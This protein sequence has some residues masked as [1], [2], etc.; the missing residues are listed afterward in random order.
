M[1]KEQ[2][3]VE[4][5]TISSRASIAQPVSHTVDLRAV[6][7]HPISINSVADEFSTEEKL[8]ILKRLKFNGLVSWDDLPLTVSFMLEK[9]SNITIEESIE[10]LRKYL[11]VHDND[12]NIPTKDYE[13][14][15]R[16]V[17][18]S[19]EDI[20]AY[21]NIKSILKESLAVDVQEVD[22]ES[23]SHDEYLIF[24]WRLQIRIEAAVIAYWSPY[25]EVRSVTDPYDDPNQAAETLRVY[26]I[27]IIWTAIGA[28]INQFF[29]QRQPSI[30]V[31]VAV[32]Q[33]F[34]YPS[35]IFLSKILPCYTF[36]LKG[37]K[38][39]LNPGPWT[40]KE[41]MI[42]TIMYGTAAASNFVT[43]NIINQKLSMFYNSTNV[44]WGYQSLLSLTNAFMG[45]GL[46]GIMR[47]F[48]IYPEVAMWPSMLP[49]MALN[50]ALVNPEKKERINGWTI[51]RYRFFWVVAI[52][53]FLWFWF[54]TY[55][56]QALSFF[57]W[58]TWIKPD[59]F[60]LAMVTGSFSGLGLNP[61]PSFDWSVL[62]DSSFAQPFYTTAAA[63]LGSVIALFFIAG[64]YW[65]NNSWTAYLPIN[66]NRMF[67]NKGEPY[68]N[69]K[70]LNSKNL[71]DEKGY[72][73]YG[74]PFYS[75]AML[76]VSGSL[77][78]FYPFAIVFECGV[79]YKDVW[80][81]LKNSI[82]GI[83]NYKKSSLQEFD[84][85]FSTM[86]Q[87][88][89][90]VPEYVFV[91]VLLCSLVFGIVCVKVYPTETPVWGI[92]FAIGINFVF[93]IPVTMLLART[94]AYFSLGTLV[95]LIVGYT[96]PGNGLAL[97]FIKA[98][99][100]N[101]DEQAENYVSNLKWAHYSKIAPWTM[102]RTQMVSVVVGNFVGLAVLNF[103]IDSVKGFCTVHQPEK[104]TC[105]GAAS[106]F[107]SSILW[108]V[109]GPKKVFGGLYPVMKYCFLIGFLL[110]LV[111]LAFKFYA[112][113]KYTKYFEPSIFLTGFQVFAPNNLSY[114]TGGLYLSAASMWYL[115]TRYQAFWEKYNYIFSSGLVSGIACCSI[116]IFFSVQYHPKE[117]NWWGNEVFTEGLDYNGA[118]LLNAT[119]LA[120]DG[121]FGPR[122]GH[123]P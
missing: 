34:M 17:E 109:I 57:N 65:R 20:G 37:M 33:L 35:G 49:A 102:F 117:I 87:N 50:R 90:E 28:F 56:F 74:P 9:I 122:I 43:S 8:F 118:S 66:S 111:C 81:S 51:S 12:V 7:S 95:E 79:R 2:A 84:D 75:A 101:I 98:L 5:T 22:S 39:N 47:R 88:Y 73:E 110:S 18:A 91:I 1:G 83:R 96:I 93:L 38:V 24:D 121:Y 26:V 70:I 115:R 108:G 45:F 53:S 97:N 80:F 113:K 48:V 32:T 100:N 69:S 23:T 52:C 104:F 89:K 94:G 3:Q 27:G 4:I 29:S 72:Q 42:V 105:P 63:Y 16:L 36:R 103:Q 112:P 54:P 41:Q 59:N 46:A 99:G 6:T 21:S 55:I 107:S 82:K 14:I 78:V 13:L 11:V 123:F 77:F 61:I 92:F 44:G 31:N 76:V 67:N 25:A 86:M 85:P 68:D 15:E 19:E 114:H 58:M 64:I 60:D 40:Y 116:V 30:S 71:F 106:F 119:I 120:P 62:N 10:V